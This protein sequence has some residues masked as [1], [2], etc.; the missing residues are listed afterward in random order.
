MHP[1]SE[2]IGDAQWLK[3]LFIKKGFI[4]RIKTDPEIDRKS[5]GVSAAGGSGFSHS[6]E[7]LVKHYNNI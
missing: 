7:Q 4:C 5:L 2:R 3:E 1:S 6:I